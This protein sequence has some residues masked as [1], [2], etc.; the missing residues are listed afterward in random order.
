MHTP[1]S[2]PPRMGR[3]SEKPMQLPVS[4]LP[5]VQLPTAGHT[6]VCLHWGTE[7]TLMQSKP[8][9]QS[10]LYV[11]ESPSLP[12]VDGC[13]VQSVRNRSSPVVPSSGSS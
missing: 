7:S 4:Q 12:P 11:Q 3:G 9:T 10:L 13:E 8:A 2:V 6:Q 5:P 1:Y